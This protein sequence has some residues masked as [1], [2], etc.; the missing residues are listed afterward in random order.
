MRGGHHRDSSFECDIS[1]PV[2]SRAPNRFLG[3]RDLPYLKLGIQDLKAK[4]GR[5]SG[6]K[7]CA[8]GGM[9]K[10]TLGI[11]GLDEILGRITGF[12]TPY[13]GSSVSMVGLWT[14]R[15]SRETRLPKKGLLLIILL[16]R[17]DVLILATHL[18]NLL[19]IFN[20]LTANSIP[21][22]HE[23]FRGLYFCRLAIFC[24]LR[25]LIVAIRTDWFLLLG[26]NFRDFQN[27]VPS[28]DNIFVF[29]EYVQQKYIFSSNKPVF[30]LWLTRDDFL[31]L[32]FCVA[33]L[34]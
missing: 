33:N 32:Y 31:V 23:I 1:L 18:H 4:S 15:H 20:R 2:V 28:I 17:T 27:P 22:W 29:I 3:T 19:F 9:P 7:L 26:I 10:L 25:E 8:G 12:K 16:Y 11:T 24:V 14:D 5:V 30:Q 34:G 13:W 21:L 6:L